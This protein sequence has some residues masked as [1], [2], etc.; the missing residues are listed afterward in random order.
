[1]RYK[2]VGHWEVGR[3]RRRLEDDLWNVTGR[4]SLPWIWWWRQ[5]KNVSLCLSNR[6]WR[7]TQDWRKSSK[8]SMLW[9]YMTVSG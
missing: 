1:L 4:D 7:C 6:S 3:L 8:Y 2:P 9:H 5:W